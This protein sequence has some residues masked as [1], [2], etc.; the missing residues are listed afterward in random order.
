MQELNVIEGL[1]Q[2]IVKDQEKLRKGE[3]KK[4]QREENLQAE[5]MAN[6]EKNAE[7]KARMDR[8]V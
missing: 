5:M 8:V 1:D 6:M 3:Y 2:N 7:L 4:R